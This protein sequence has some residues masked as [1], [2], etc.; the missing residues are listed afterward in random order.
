MTTSLLFLV[1]DIIV[2]FRAIFT[3]LLGN[4]LILSQLS[5]SSL[6]LQEISG[7]CYHIELQAI[8]RKQNIGVYKLY[9]N[10]VEYAVTKHCQLLNI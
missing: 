6:Q 5:V 4:K 9:T 7:Y 1:P 2:R 8:I 3:L 10:I